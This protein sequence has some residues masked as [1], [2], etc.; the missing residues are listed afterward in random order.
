[1]L[2]LKAWDM[3]KQTQPASL[4]NGG[5]SNEFHDFITAS[6]QFSKF[7]K[8]GLILICLNCTSVILIRQINL[9]PNDNYQTDYPLLLFDKFIFML[10]IFSSSRGVR[11]PSVRL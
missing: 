9:T 8:R 3:S 6:N 5:D 7:G 2:S 11:R 10:I 4:D 1:M